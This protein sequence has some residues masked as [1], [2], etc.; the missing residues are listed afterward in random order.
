MLYPYCHKGFH[1]LGNIAKS[2]QTRR[3]GAFWMRGV[4]CARTGATNRRELWKMRNLLLKSSPILGVYRDLHR[5]RMLTQERQLLCCDYGY[6]IPPELVGTSMEAEYHH[7]M[8]RA[9]QVFDTIA[10]ELPEETQSSSQWRTMCAGISMSICAPCNGFANCAPLLRG[11]R[12]TATS[13][14]RWRHRFSRYFPNFAA[15]SNSSISAVMRWGEWPR[16]RK[17]L[18]S[19]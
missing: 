5:H 13:L 19:K 4:R 18:K 7:A 2:S 1:D 8:E 9:K 14:K 3:S 15:S 6:T 12:I 11:T 16:S 17:K 10:Q